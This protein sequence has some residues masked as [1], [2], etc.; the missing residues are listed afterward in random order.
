MLL[1][2]VCGASLLIG[3]LVHVQVLAVQFYNEKAVHL[4]RRNIPLPAV[5]GEILDSAG[6]SLVYTASAASIIAVPRQIK[7]KQRTAYLLWKIIGG[8]EQGILKLLSQPKLM[9]YIRPRGRRL[10]EAKV[11]AIRALRLPGIYLTEEGKRE[12][13]Y[14]DLAAQVLGVTGGEGQGLSGIELEFN[15]V[16]AGQKGALQFVSNARGEE[17]PQTNDDYIP[18]V[19]GLDVELTLN[20]QI[21]QFAQREIQN[22]VA[23]YAPDH[24]TIIVA[25]PNSGQILAMAN[26][27]TFNPANWRSVPQQ[28]YNR[29]LAIWQTFEPGSTFKIVTLAAALQEKKVNLKERFYD[30]GYYEVAGHKIKCWKAGGHGSQ[31]YLNVVENSCNPGF[32]QLGERLGKTQLFSFIRA[33]GFGKK[34]GITLPGEGKGILFNPSRVGPL[35][36]ATTAFG[37]G[38]SVTP[39]QQ[40]MAMSAIANGGI[41]MKPEIVKAFINPTTGQVVKTFQPVAVHRVISP[42][43][44]AQVRDALESVVAQGTGGAAFREGWRIGGKTGTAQVVENGHYSGAH[45]I[46]SFIGMAPV[47]HPQLVAYVA[48]DYPRP[49]GTPVFG[50]VIAAPVIGNLL[51]DSLQYLNVPPSLQGIPKKYRYGIDPVLTTVPGLAGRSYK[52]A[53]RTMLE[54]GTILRVAVVGEGPYVIAQAPKEGTKLPQGSTVRLY[55]GPAP[56]GAG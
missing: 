53:V 36:L 42:E 46:V 54:S 16:L 27:P 30:P 52:D 19:P 4:I 35:E 6:Q 17:I 28:V 5:R 2:F 45:Y 33:F 43:V 10:D 21:Q 3:R 44:A 51:A 14:G 56:S 9:V 40:V 12:Y 38:V 25:N 47:N 39:I 13:P 26:Y 20:R 32:I 11:K 15:Q 50:G 22:I 7:D 1:A 49:K 31:S 23:K 18:P 41:L 24:V 29:N 8:T 55:L 34:T 37:Q 48:I